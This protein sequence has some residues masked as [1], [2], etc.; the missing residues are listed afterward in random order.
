MESQVGKDGDSQD[1][2][3][4]DMDSSDST[5]LSEAEHQDSSSTASEIRLLYVVEN[6][7][8]SASKGKEETISSETTSS[9]DD[10]LFKEVNKVNN[11]SEEAVAE[12]HR[13]DQLD[14]TKADISSSSSSSSSSCS[15]G[16]SDV[17][18]PGDAVKEATGSGKLGE[19]H[20]KS[21]YPTYRA[22]KQQREDRVQAH[23]SPV[24]MTSVTQ[25]ESDTPRAVIQVKTNIDVTRV[26]NRVTAPSPRP[27][28]K[29]RRDYSLQSLDDFQKQMS[30]KRYFL[31]DPPSLSQNPWM[32]FA[33]S[34]FRIRNDQMEY[35]SYSLPYLNMHESSYGNCTGYQTS[36]QM[37]AAYRRLSHDRPHK[38]S[39]R[40]QTTPHLARADTTNTCAKRPYTTPRTSRYMNNFREDHRH[41]SV[42]IEGPVTGRYGW[43]KAASRSK[44][45][46]SSPPWRSLMNRRPQGLRDQQQLCPHFCRCCFN[47]TNAQEGS[48]VYRL[49]CG[50]SK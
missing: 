21:R 39:S 28:W 33:G 34:P 9:K 4:T 11:M 44:I 16:N 26:K 49:D 42:A 3:A 29:G 2:I 37:E 24:R 6:R 40:P 14:F 31:E 17:K 22:I 15:S 20:L 13:I 38:S 47:K 30:Q 43:Y 7:T 10:S 12:N 27:A 19:E 8:Q 50:D 35:P 41:D 48:S 5:M 18:S 25:F 36:R 32:S 45:V 1:N 46:H 23:A